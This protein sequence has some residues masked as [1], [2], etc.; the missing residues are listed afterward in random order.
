MDPRTPAAISDP[1]HMS[2]P[3][4]PLE[5]EGME[6]DVLVDRDVVVVLAIPGV[7]ATCTIVGV[8]PPEHKATLPPPENVASILSTMTSPELTEVPEF[9]VRV[10]GMLV[11]VPQSLPPAVKVG[12][13][14]E[15]SN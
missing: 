13:L 9:A 1:T 2:R 6:E 15:A 3:C 12:T 7:A 4:C 10:A 5:V 8:F 11:E 14:P